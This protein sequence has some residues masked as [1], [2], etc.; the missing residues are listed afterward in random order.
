MKE[1]KREKSSIRVTEGDIK[2]SE[3]FSQDSTISPMEKLKK[4]LIFGLM[5][6]VFLGC[7]YL[8]FNPSSGKE[9]SEDSLL[10][11]SV[12]EATSAELPIDKGKAYEQEMLDRKKEE[13]RKALLT[14][15]DYWNN[16]EETEQPNDG[17]FQ[18]EQN[19]GTTENQ[20]STG[21]SNPSLNSYRN[22]QSTLGNF[23]EE[24]SSETKKLRKELEELKEQLAERDIPE[25]LTIDDQL[26]LMEKSYQMA[27]K[28]LPGNNSNEDG[29][30]NTNTQKPLDK[31][32]K[33]DLTPLIPTG[34]NPVTSLY[35]QETDTSFFQEWFSKNRNRFYSAGSVEQLSQAKN[36]IKAVVQETQTI[37]GEAMVR[38]R[39]LEAAKTPQ[40]TL[41]AGTLITANAKFQSGR[42]QLN[43]NSI[44]WNERIIPVDIVVYDLDGQQGLAVP[45]S[46]E[47]NALTEMA[48][49]MSQNAGTSIMLTQSAGQQAAADLGRGV[50]QGVSGYF[51][52]KVRT[53]KVTLKAGYQ[54]LLLSK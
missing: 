4:P 44:E 22:M 30:V 51:S 45:Y 27:T 43:V 32:A 35:R 48:G 5:G 7:L 34:K 29:Q 1:N 12:P 25:P 36:S 9:K 54:V 21:Y 49:N 46:P 39:L 28:Y 40:Y 23:Y 14:L 15:S 42:L 38:L 16:S 10:N 8:I 31:N 2:E 19:E 41:P 11:E 52:K 3:D 53:P 33:A 50:I 26:A 18:D 6:I 37:V 17:L 47:M 24:E 13:K 20:T